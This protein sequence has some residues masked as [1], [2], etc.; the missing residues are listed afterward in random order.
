MVSIVINLVNYVLYIKTLIIFNNNIVTSLDIMV[1][2][3]SAV[4]SCAATSDCI[5]G[6]SCDSSANCGKYSY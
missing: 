1:L 5:S 2:F 6:E 3:I 4:P